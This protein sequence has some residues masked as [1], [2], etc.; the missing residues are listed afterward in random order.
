MSKIIILI[1]GL[2]ASIALVGCNTTRTI[3]SETPSHYKHCKTKEV[4]KLRY[5]NE[6]EKGA[7]PD[8]YTRLYKSNSGSSMKSDYSRAMV[9]SKKTANCYY[10]HIHKDDLVSKPKYHQN[11]A[12]VRA[13][14]ACVNDGN[15]ITDCALVDSVNFDRRQGYARYPELKDIDHIYAAQ[16]FN[17]E[18]FQKI[19]DPSLVYTFIVLGKQSGRKGGGL[20]TRTD[21]RYKSDFDSSYL[22]LLGVLNDCTDSFQGSCGLVGFNNV[23]MKLSDWGLS[24]VGK[25]WGSAD[26]LHEGS[27]RQ[28]YT[29]SGH[30]VAY[31]DESHSKENSYNRRSSVD[32][33][34]AVNNALKDANSLNKMWDSHTSGSQG[35]YSSEQLRAIAESNDESS[36]SGAGAESDDSDLQMWCVKVLAKDPRA[37]GCSR[38]RKKSPPRYDHKGRKMKPACTK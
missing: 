31:L 7:F 11:V 27:S 18:F 16:R 26:T 22:A 14:Q 30:H 12:Y 6:M 37:C 24:Y 1:L 21:W 17:E 23:A 38:F 2:I 36:D 10:A 25:K 28:Y 35:Y 29:Q 15:L 8:N 33:S 20:Y 9:S 19:K 3:K 5:G 34:S 13:L 4:K 32:I